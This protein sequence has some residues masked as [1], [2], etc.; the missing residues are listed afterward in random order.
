MRIRVR[1]LNR[2]QSYL[3]KRWKEVAVSEIGSETRP[4]C[5]ADHCNS[6]PDRFN[7]NIN[8]TQAS[9]ERILW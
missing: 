9:V 2:V 6:R 4:V 3:H 8:C 1:G 5:A 7:S